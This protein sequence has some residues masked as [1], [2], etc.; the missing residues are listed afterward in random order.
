MAEQTEIKKVI[1]VDLGNTTTSLKD[2]KKHI[3]ELRGSLLQ[4]D[5]SSEEYAKIAAEIKTEQDKLNEVMKVGKKDTDAV[6]GSYN[7]LS[8]TMAELK[9]Q[10]K[11]TGDEA[12]R[13]EL[14]KKI[15]EINNQ[16]KE[17][18]AS[19]GNFQRN[20]GDY[21]NS[22]KKAM[23][24]LKE[25]VSSNIP[26]MGKL[27]AAM[28]L[29]A[30]NP[31]IAVIGALVGTF[32]LLINAIKGSEEQTQKISQAFSV[33]TPILNGIKNTIS[34][35]ADGVVFLAQKA[36][37]AAT[38][39]MMKIKT[40]FSSLGFDEWAEKIQNALDKMAESAQIKKQE[41]DLQIQSR[42]NL[43]KEADLNRE[44]SDLRA[45]MSDK[46]QYTSEERIKFL[47]QWEAKEKELAE[48]KRK[49]AQEEYD[50]IVKKN[51]L[52][53]SGSQDLDAE[54]QAYANLQR[55]TQDYNESLRTINK[56]RQG[57]LNEMKGGKN[58]ATVTKENMDEAVETIDNETQAI[59]DR[60]EK[61]KKS[62]LELL[63]DKY[64][65]EKAKLEK[66]GIDITDL[67]EEYEKNRLEILKKNADEELKIQAK[68]LSDKQS[69]LDKA[70]KQAE[71]DVDYS[72]EILTEQEK[73]DAKFEIEQ[74]LIQRKIDLNTEYLAT[75]EAGTEEYARI[76]GIINEL[77]QQSFNNEKKY[78]AES[79]KETKKTE[80]E[81]K[82]AREAAIMAGLSAIGSMLDS[83]ADMEEEGSQKQK[84]LQVAA[85]VVNT[86]AGS[87]GAFLQGMASYPLPY[88][89][90]I[91][92]IAATAATVAG[93]AQIAKIKSSNKNSSPSSASVATPSM[94]ELEMTEVSPLLDEQADLNRIEMSN[95]EGDSEKQEQ[96]IRC[97]VVESDITNMQN[98]VSVVE[99]NATF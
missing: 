86:L 71:F 51:S 50:L 49:A 65:Q 58:I 41:I 57:I 96:N 33:F 6:D 28:K 29:V 39:I 73:A 52:T 16:L 32:K 90:I 85:A 7:K 61:G 46:E 94:P 8:Q 18:D 12:E 81:K 23:G 63:E 27:N 19:T 67:T 21:E 53:K 70:A 83:I 47:N 98:K 64:N 13:N 89:A 1:S 11:A 92:G 26:A 43:K 34:G 25:G 37:E 72:D 82:K 10:W 22:F 9:K 36:S 48:M 84:D 38:S 14:G 97:Y 60:L 78:N 31:I 55:A 80:N 77:R 79:V 88:G 3:D 45:K 66:F 2:Y 75:L 74:N 99:D 42:E 4:L 76:E 69:A 20:V 59:L 5:E 91:G 68:V 30:A 87:I 17:L 44:I 54:A 95:V 24:S 15:L 40:V 56:T 35:I 62:E 93:V